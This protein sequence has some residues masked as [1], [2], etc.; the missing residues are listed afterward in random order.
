[1]NLRLD[2]YRFYAKTLEG[3]TDYPMLLALPVP[4]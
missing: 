1:M 4:T 2:M 3:K